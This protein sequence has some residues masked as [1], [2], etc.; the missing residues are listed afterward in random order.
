MRRFFT[1][2]V[3]F[4]AASS[5]VL[6]HAASAQGW[7]GSKNGQTLYAVNDSLKYGSLFVGIGTNQPAAQLHTTGS[8]RL[9][10]ITQNTSTGRLLVQD[11]TGN[12]YWRDL[13]GISTASGW[14]LTG[15]AGTNSSNFLGTTDNTPLAFRT[16]NVEKVTIL[17]N[18]NVGI[19]ISQPGKL[20]QVH[21]SKTDSEDNNIMVSGAAPSLYFSKTAVQPNATPY[22]SPYA[23]IGL[24]T[25]ATTFATTSQP[26]D[27]VIHT[28]AQGASILFALGVDA[29]GTNGVEKARF[30]SNGNLGV[31]TT[32]PTAKLHINGNVR[33]QNLPANTGKSLVV[34]DSGYVYVATKV[35]DTTAVNN[36]N[37]IAA[38]QQEV[39]LLKQALADM[40]T[41]LAAI[42][43]GT[44]DVVDNGAKTA[45]SITASPN[46][47]NGAATL[48]YTYPATASSAYIIISDMNGRQ[49]KR[50]DLKG[51]STGSV[52]VTLDSN[53]PTGTYI[54]N[55]EVDG[56][57]VGSKKLIYSK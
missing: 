10:G 15:N 19:G 54:S 16:A 39:A 27:F 52:T 31:N 41:Q 46:P 17:S 38:L 8:V 42:K 48:K 12:V 23:R 22:N 33:F 34:D 21:N 11:T 9:S 51:N 26:G 29:A 45:S 40:Q 4:L 32:N 49:L 6:S 14:S 44:V 13:S 56:K 28:I 5:I 35:T 25:R 50:Y 57:I 37:D 53:S 2:K 24:S 47:F 55:L 20:L 43:S 3:F 18:G 36:A 7:V 30:N 1:Q